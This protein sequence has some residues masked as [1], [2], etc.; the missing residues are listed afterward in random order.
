MED[1]NNLLPVNI[2]IADRTYRLKVKVEDEEVLRKTVK[3][4]NE[5]IVEYKTAFA[6]KD[7]Q[8]YVSMVLIWL[9]TEETKTAE[10]IVDIHNAVDKITILENQLDKILVKVEDELEITN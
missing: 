3:I 7:M 10:H 5:K 4:I 2:A 9:A 8:D 6:G 1:N